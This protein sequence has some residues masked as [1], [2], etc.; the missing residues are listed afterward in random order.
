M[1]K[2]ESQ[3]IDALTDGLARHRPFGLPPEARE[4]LRQRALSHCV[5]GVPGISR[6]AVKSLEAVTGRAVSGKVGMLELLKLVPKDWRRAREA[7]G[8]VRCF[9][10][11]VAEVVGPAARVAGFATSAGV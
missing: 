8:A 2:I 11:A 1:K 7:I 9:V 6:R 4:R 3:I 5:H 10:I